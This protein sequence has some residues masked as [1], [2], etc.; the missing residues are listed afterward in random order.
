MFV[1][2]KPHKFIID[3][4]IN[5]TCFDIVHMP[6]QSNRNPRWGFWFHGL[7]Q[8]SKWM[9]PHAIAPCA[10][11]FLSCKNWVVKEFLIFLN[12][13]ND[14]CVSFATTTTTQQQTRWGKHLVCLLNTSRLFEHKKSWWH[15]LN[16]RQKNCLPNDTFRK[17]TMMRTMTKMQH[18]HKKTQQPT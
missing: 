7:S 13:H 5:V 18:K 2:N 8:M 10:Q 14:D 6:H 17:Q 1:F 3:F 9:L 15:R 16:I 11:P 12:Q 4:W